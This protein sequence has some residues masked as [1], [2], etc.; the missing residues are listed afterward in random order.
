MKLA[1]LQR[2][3]QQR[4]HIKMFF[5]TDTFCGCG[6]VHGLRQSGEEVSV[7]VGVSVQVSLVSGSFVEPDVPSM[8]LQVSNS[9]LLTRR[10]QTHRRHL[11]GREV[12]RDY[13]L[14][15]ARL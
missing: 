6:I 12:P 5:V 3:L 8:V 2:L 1:A 11:A 4:G 15:V 13:W 14:R 7:D 9:T 10:L